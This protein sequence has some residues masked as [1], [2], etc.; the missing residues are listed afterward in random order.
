MRCE[1]KLKIP[2]YYDEQQIKK[3]KP[4]RKYEDS[5][6][7]TDEN[8]IVKGVGVVKN[9]KKWNYHNNYDDSKYCM[10]FDNCKKWF[11]TDL[12]EIIRLQQENQE[13]WTK[14]LKSE[15]KRVKNL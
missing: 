15:L 4:D 12:R 14:V 2:Y 5:Y 13:L 7:L 9:D 3:Y 11:T 8:C 6:S 1:L 10:Y